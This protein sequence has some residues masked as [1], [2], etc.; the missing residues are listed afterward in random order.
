[1]L[2]CRTGIPTAVAVEHNRS[3]WIADLRGKTICL[4]PGH[5][6]ATVGAHGRRLSEYRVCWQVALK[7]QEALQAEGATVVMTKHNVDENVKN[8]DRAA[9]ANGCH[10]DL[11]LRLHCDAGAGSGIATYYPD[12]QGVFNGVRG[13]ERDVMEASR[14]LI[15]RFHPAM[16]KALH[17]ALHDRGIHTDA[18]TYVGG[19][20]GGALTGSIYSRVPVLLV[21]MCVLTNPKD[22]AFIGS[23]SGKDRV[24]AAMAAGV[25]AAVADSAG[26]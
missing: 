10:A 7:L 3:S 11:F 4:D 23:D 14:R 13:P 25:A 21:E 26:P 17:S 24:V 18:E 19:R 1:V 6:R 22:E 15:Y 5:S 12:R 8:E 2:L 9:I 16:I 20:Q